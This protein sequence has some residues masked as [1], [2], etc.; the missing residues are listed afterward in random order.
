LDRK[1]KEL[2]QAAGVSSV[3][4]AKLSCNENVATDS[5]VKI[6]STLHCDIIMEVVALEK[7]LPP[8]NI[9]FI[10]IFV[11]LDVWRDKYEL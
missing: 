10:R 8:N 11:S 2:R 5:L 7:M 9:W 4:I 6:C 1:K 3:L